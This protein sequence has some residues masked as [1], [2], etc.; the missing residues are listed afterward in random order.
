MSSI[1]ISI[2]GSITSTDPK[3][4]PWTVLTSP[5]A[6]DLLSH[7][8]RGPVRLASID[9]NLLMALSTISAI[10]RE[11][12]QCYINFPCVMHQDLVE[13]DAVT[14][15]AANTLVAQIEGMGDQLARLAGECIHASCGVDKILFILVGCVGLDWGGLELLGD[16]GMLARNPSKP[17]GRYVLF[18]CET[19]Y[20]GNGAIKYTDSHNSRYGSYVFTSFGRG[21]RR[22]CFPD[23]FWQMKNENL[24]TIDGA[25]N[26]TL[27]A[28]VGD[29][30]MSTWAENI[31]LTVL[32]RRTDRQLMQVLEQLHYLRSGKP[33]I[34]VFTEDDS[35]VVKSIKALVGEVIATWAEREYNTIRTRLASI[36]PN[37]NGVSYAETFN[38]V[39]HSIFGMANG[40]LA[41]RSFF[42]DPES[43]ENEW[44]GYLP[45][46]HEA[47][48]N[49]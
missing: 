43:K 25:L 28:S 30:P 7:L 22:R 34:P 4:N 39:W 45:A 38:L 5:P 14:L 9:E 19:G 40:I 13:I 18:G 17:G 46:V 21:A 10:R 41:Q 2:A 42:F 33:N 15:D 1:G 24:L 29:T 35:I 26:E 44:E 11:G 37:R 6:Q 48:L 8:A 36:G 12:D 49:L 31:G 16:K 3:Y 47:S 23:L 27:Q 32:G 20:Y